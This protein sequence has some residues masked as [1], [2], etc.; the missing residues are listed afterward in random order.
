MKLQLERPTPALLYC[1]LKPLLSACTH[2]STSNFLLDVGALKVCIYAQCSI[3]PTL[4]NVPVISAAQCFLSPALH[5]LPVLSTAQG[6]LF[7]VLHNAPC[8]LCCTMLLVFCAVQ[9]SLSSA[10]HNAACPL[11]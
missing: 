7:S 5:Y 11:Y 8:T 6:S 3:S 4:R 9:C 2:V 1:L 10:L